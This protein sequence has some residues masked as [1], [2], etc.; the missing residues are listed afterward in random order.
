[1]TH[2]WP[3]YMRRFNNI[4]LVLSLTKTVQRTGGGIDV[5]KVRLPPQEVRE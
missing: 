1:M 5:I 3:R 2:G 4:I